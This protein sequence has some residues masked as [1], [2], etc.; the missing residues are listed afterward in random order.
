MQT[1]LPHYREPWFLERAAGRYRRFLALRR[2]HP[3]QFLVPTYDIDVGG[4]PTWC[5]FLLPWWSLYS[6]QSTNPHSSW[7]QS[8]WSRHCAPRP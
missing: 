3:T 5:R 1:N 2:R 6:L 7:T 8:Y 4:M